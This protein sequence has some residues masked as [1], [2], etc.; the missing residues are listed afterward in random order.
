MTG[1]I[2][3][4][5]A[6]AQAQYARA[7]DALTAGKPRE[8]AALAKVLVEQAPEH[9]DVLHLLAGIRG[10]LGDHAGAVNAVRQ[11]LHAR[12]DD[13]TFCC[14]LG[15]Q[16]AAIGQL[17]AAIEAL[18]RACALQPE[19]AMAWYNLGVL[20]VR[21]VRFNEAEAALRRTLELVPDNLQARLQL[22][23]LLKMAGR[24]DAAA[25]T[26]REVLAARPASGD[27]WW[28]LAELGQAG[29]DDIPAMQVAMRDPRASERDRIAL[30]FAIARVLDRSDRCAEAMGVLKET[31]AHARKLQPWDAAAFARGLDA[32]L[33][34]FAATRVTG[35]ACGHGAIFIASLPRSGSTLTE[36]VLAAHSQVEASGELRDLPQVLAEESRQRGRHYPEWVSSMAEDDWRRLGERY[37]ERTARWRERKPFFTDKLPGNWMHVGVI[38]AMLPGA[39]VIV[40]RRDPLETCF[41]CYRQYMTADGQGWTHR[42][43]DLAAYWNVFDRAL[44]QWQAR[45]PGFVYTQ[46]YETLLAEPEASVRALLAFCGLPFEDAC[47]AFGA[48]SREVRSPSAMQ[49]RE[50]L[51][52]DTARAP[53]YG[54]LLDPL[55]SA[56]GV[57]DIQSAH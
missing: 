9:P 29:D 37:L 7:A 23:D 47:L 6:Q 15:K 4:L 48:G 22:A 21:A 50:P 36:Q 19:L 24:V 40:C 28:G 5:D 31:H 49:V 42:F 30:G 18:Q 45:Y 11:A 14:T 33:A 57:I 32:V 44:W 35:A 51:R 38:R 26:W 2:Q 25:A 39:K 54:A 43:E 12:P 27:A 10:R 55:R 53:R 17:D 56:L 13:A 34:A 46:E 20:Q 41:S 3:G 8:A 52:R 16:L 1:G